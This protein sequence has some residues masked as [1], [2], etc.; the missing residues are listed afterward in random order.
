MVHHT[1]KESCIVCADKDMIK[2]MDGCVPACVGE[3][4]TSD[5][6]Y[7]RDLIETERPSC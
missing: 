6:L 2:Q 7:G 4:V 1:D 5:R 3:L